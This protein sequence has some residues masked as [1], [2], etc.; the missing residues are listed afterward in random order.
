MSTAVDSLTA[1]ASRLDEVADSA[2]H[3]ASVMD[4]V[5]DGLVDRAMDLVRRAD[6]VRVSVVRARD[7][8]D[9][10]GV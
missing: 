1:A 2:R 8:L 6:D 3:A 10:A 9:H 4:G 7:S 5:S